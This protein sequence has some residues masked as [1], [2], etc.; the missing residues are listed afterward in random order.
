MASFTQKQKI[1]IAIFLFLFAAIKISMLFWW[2]QQQNTITQ[3]TLPSNCEVTTPQGCEFQTGQRLRLIGVG[4]NKT[5]FS[6]RIDGLPENVTSVN[7]SFDMRDMPMGFNRF[8]LKKQPD[9]SWQIAQIFLPLCSSNRHD[10]QVKWR[11]DGQ[12]YQ[13]EFKTTP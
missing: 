8:D 5:P 11:I 6:A 7:L 1:A 12:E 13:A 9:G 10:W 3:T 2:Q 4:N